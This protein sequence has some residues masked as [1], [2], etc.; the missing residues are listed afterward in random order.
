MKYKTINAGDKIGRWKILYRTKV[1]RRIA[2]F[3]EFKN[4]VWNSKI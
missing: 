3:C 2:W 4:S 1:G